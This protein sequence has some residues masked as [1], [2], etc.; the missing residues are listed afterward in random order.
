MGFRQDIVAG[1]TTMMDAFISAN[2]TLLVR[3]FRSR[4]ESEKD[5]PATYLDIRP[6]T[7]AH[8]AGVRVRT[9]SPAIV[10][11]TRLTESGQT[12][13]EHDALVDALVDHFTLYPHIAAGTVWDAM[14]VSDESAGADNQFA[15]TR[16]V[17]NDV[18]DGVG[19][20]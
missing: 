4:P 5:L 13:D 15:A 1:V 17:F 9:M 3:H 11:V 18:S 8:S 12:S 19:R 14:T 16:F 6:E 20:D 10:L 7:V 2:P